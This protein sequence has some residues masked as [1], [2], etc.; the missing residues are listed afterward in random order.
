VIWR[1]GKGPQLGSVPA[2][3]ERNCLTDNVP[4][5][6]HLPDGGNKT[7]PYP[8]DTKNIGDGLALLRTI[9]SDSIATA[10]FD[11]QYRELLDYLA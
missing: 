10:F 3:R 5:I 6:A 4:F 9:A 2:P 11:P 8:L 1:K 7:V